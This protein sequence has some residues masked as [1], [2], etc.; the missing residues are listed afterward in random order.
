MKDISQN[1]GS[2]KIG[3]EIKLTEI[4]TQHPEV[5][6]PKVGILIANLGTPEA[7]D[8][9]SVRRYLSE[10]LSDRRV[11]DYTPWVWQIILQTIILTRRPFSSGAAYKSIWN[12]DTNE[13]PLLTNVRTQAEKLR[14]SLKKSFG[15]N[16]IVEFSMRYGKPSTIKTIHKMKERGCDRIIFL[17][18]YPQYSAPTTGTA[19]DEAFRA[20]MKLKWQPAIRTIP[21]YFDKPGYI[22]CLANSILEKYS[23]M[24]VNPDHLVVSYHGVPERYLLAGDPYHCHCQKTTRLLKEELGWNDKCITTTFQ[25][26]FG[27]GKWLGPPTVEYVANLG[28]LGKKSI[29][30]IAPAFSSDCIETL[31]EIEEE[32]RDSFLEAGGENFYY[33]ECL[34]SRDD[35]IDFLHNLIVNEAKGWLN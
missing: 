12:N 35:H 5:L 14:I 17:P 27:P 25:S 19:N 33:I 4:P 34:N 16:I 30:V 7:T 24:D 23:Q 10:F 6:I 31:E 28:K 2:K 26:K 20:L 9:W 22:R 13:S 15:D 8:Y 29:A 11:I 21:A 18:L 1:I 3:S 32:I